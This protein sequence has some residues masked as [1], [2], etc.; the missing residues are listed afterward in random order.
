MGEKGGGVFRNKTSCGDRIFGGSPRGV[1]EPHA[2]GVQRETW[3][4]SPAECRAGSRP[5]RNQAGSRAS[6]P[7]W[8]LILDPSDPNSPLPG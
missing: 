8:T 6:L 7:A 3:R 5:E 4:A 1:P 2:G